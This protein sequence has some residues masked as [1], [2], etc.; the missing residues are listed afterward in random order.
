[1]AFAFKGQIGTNHEQEIGLYRRNVKQAS[2]MNALSSP[3]IV[4]LE[5]SLSDLGPIRRA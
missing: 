5:D 4:D 3:A 1:M 2:G